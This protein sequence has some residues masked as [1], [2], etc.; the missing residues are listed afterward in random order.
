MRRHSLM[1]VSALAI[2]LAT[3]VSAQQTSTPHLYMLQFKNAPQ[4]SKAMIESPQDRSVPVRKLVEGFG[5]RL[6][7]YYFYPPGEYDGMVIAELP[8]EV[9]ADALALTVSSTG[10][11]LKLNLVPLITAEQGK[12]VM[13]KAKETRTGYTPPTETK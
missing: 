13:E 1:I 7:G 6:L 8:D 3:P 5:G 11:T 10:N 4:A 9:A 2:V 12:A